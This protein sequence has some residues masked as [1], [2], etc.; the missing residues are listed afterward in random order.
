M[1]NT[2][3]PFYPFGE[4]GPKVILLGETDWSLN[5]LQAEG[6]SRSNP[7]LFFRLNQLGQQF[8]FKD[9]LAP[10]PVDFNTTICLPKDLPISIRD[11][12]CGITVRR[13]CKADGVVL[14]R[15]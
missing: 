13:G 15:G 11:G 3:P 9:L 8:G 12:A 5:S 4:N 7:G 2:F 14:R 6:D 10:S 1:I